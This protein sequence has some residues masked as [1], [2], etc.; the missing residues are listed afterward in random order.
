VQSLLPTRNSKCIVISI[1][2]LYPIDG[3]QIDRFPLFAKGADFWPL[4]ELMII[5]SIPGCTPRP[6]AMTA[7]FGF[8]SKYREA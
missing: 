3:L 6:F 7:T 5:S 4:S 1:K 2:A 8:E